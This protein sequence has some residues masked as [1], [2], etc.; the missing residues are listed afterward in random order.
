MDHCEGSPSLQRRAS[1]S[2]DAPIAIITK[3]TFVV[4]SNNTHPTSRLHRARAREE[5]SPSKGETLRLQSEGRKV[6][7][8]RRTFAHDA[9]RALTA[10]ARASATIV[11]SRVASS[12]P[13]APRGVSPPPP[14]RPR[15]ETIYIHNLVR[16]TTRNQRRTSSSSAC[17]E[18]TSARSV[19]SFSPRARARCRR[20]TRIS[21]R[22]TKRKSSRATHSRRRRTRCSRACG[23]RATCKRIFPRAT[24]RG[25]RSRRRRRY[26]GRRWT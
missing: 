20:R 13:L 21:G 19:I 16:S 10:L 9:M 6:T 22:R 7:T 1:V 25:A 3:R 23:I 2:I 15:D 12:A 5:D 11:R 26:S 17:V 18:T 8:L 14:P 4:S 24:S